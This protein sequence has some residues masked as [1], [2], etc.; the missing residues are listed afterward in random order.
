MKKQHLAMTHDQPG[1][2]RDRHYGIMKLEEV[3]EGEAFHETLKRLEE[4]EKKGLASSSTSSTSSTTSTASPSSPSTTAISND[5]R[6]STLSS[7]AHGT[8][9]F[10]T[11]ARQSRAFSSTSTSSSLSSSS[12]SL[13]SS[14]RKLQLPPQ[15]F[16]DAVIK[17]VSKTTKES[18][19]N[20]DPSSSVSSVLSTWE[21]SPI[22]GDR[23]RT[24]LVLFC[25]ANGYLARVPLK[26]VFEF[27]AGLYTLLTRLPPP[28]RHRKESLK[29]SSSSTSS[30]SSPHMSL[31]DKVIERGAGNDLFL[32]NTSRTIHQSLKAL[33]L[34]RI[35]LNARIAKEES[36]KREEEAI[37]A[38]KKRKEEKNARGST[39]GSTFASFFFGGGR[40]GS[41]SSTTTPPPSSP[42]PSASSSSNGTLLD[43]LPPSSPTSSFSSSSSSSFSFDDLIEGGSIAPEGIQ[44]IHRLLEI[45]STMKN[46]THVSSVPPS[47]SINKNKR[48]EEGVDGT[49]INKDL[50]INTKG[51]EI[52]YNEEMI[53]DIACL[54]ALHVS[55]AS[56]IKIVFED[57]K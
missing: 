22:R 18:S 4:K 16:A 17:P 10:S 21:D 39:G 26:R 33:E 55:V 45:T 53:D 29:N 24:F 32:L 48:E 1:G 19:D 57:E 49:T 30:S 27:E 43:T 51:Q 46:Q 31:L 35:I 38:E 20:Q 36:K 40:G 28:N 52:T 13:P 11:F 6:D 5:S 8:R 47:D 23:K 9:K 37:L 14:F 41:S 56:F 2:T 34:S 50:L 12:S 54:A 42:P 15:V 7:A 44:A 3:I 25:I